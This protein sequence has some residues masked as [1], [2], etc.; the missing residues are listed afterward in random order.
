MPRDDASGGQ[1]LAV[2]GLD[3]ADFS[4]RNITASVIVTE[5]RSGLTR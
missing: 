1:G 5:N 3:D 2:A 4:R